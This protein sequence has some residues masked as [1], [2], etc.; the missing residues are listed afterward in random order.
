MPPGCRRAECL[1]LMEH[2]AYAMHSNPKGKQV[3]ITR[4]A[5]AHAVAHCFRAVPEED[6]TAAA[7]RFLEEEETDSGILVSRGNILRFWHQTF[8]EYLAATVLERKDRDRQRLLFDEGKLYS[9]DWRETVLLLSGVLC[10][11]D[12]EEVDAFL[13]EVLDRLGP[14]ATLAERARTVG[15]IGR[16]LQDLESWNYRIVDARYRENLDCVPAIFDAKRGPADR[17]CNPPGGGGCPGPGGGPETEAGQL[18]EGGGRTVLD[19]SA[20]EQSGRA[21]L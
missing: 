1:E 5:A 12:P 18:G 11:Q 20:E 7:E 8:Q 19:G 14:N 10:G 6:R 21:E 3:E 17:L 16:I 15:L 4:H 2:L 9:P 13:E